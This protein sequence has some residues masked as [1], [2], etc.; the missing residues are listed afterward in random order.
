MLYLYGVITVTRRGIKTGL[1]GAFKNFLPVA[2]RA[3]NRAGHFN[4]FI[5]RSGFLNAPRLISNYNSSFLFLKLLRPLYARTYTHN[6]WDRPHLSSASIRDVR[7]SSAYSNIFFNQF[8]TSY[9]RSSSVQNSFHV[10]FWHTLTSY[11]DRTLRIGTYITS[12]GN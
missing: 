1:G 8:Y 2:H 12:R 7:S 6:T 11:N 3:R 4:G 9:S 5:V 10:P